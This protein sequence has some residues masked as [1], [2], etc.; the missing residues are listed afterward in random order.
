[1]SEQVVQ[2]HPLKPKSGTKWV[3]TFREENVGIYQ[4]Y[5]VCQDTSTQYFVEKNRKG[6]K[7]LKIGKKLLIYRHQAINR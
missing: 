4:R 7:S 5:I 6:E 2:A 1:M 3:R